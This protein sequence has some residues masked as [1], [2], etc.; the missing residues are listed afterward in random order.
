MFFTCFIEYIKIVNITNNVFSQGA[1]TMQ[2]FLYIGYLLIGFIQLFAIMD[3][4][5]Y[6]FGIGGFLSFLIAI[7]T[8]YIPLVGAALGVYGAINMWDWTLLQAGLLFFWYIP[9]YFLVAF[10]D[11]N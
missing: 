1:I 11:R 10:F 3:G 8:T 9:F 2:L 5:L 4:L 6:A 7:F